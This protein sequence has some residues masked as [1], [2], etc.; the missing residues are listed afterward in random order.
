MRQN[1]Y[2]CCRCGREQRTQIEVDS[3]PIGWALITFERAF[4][5]A[6]EGKQQ[7]KN[8]HVI[9][10]RLRIVLRGRAD[11]S[12]KGLAR[13]R[14]V[15]R[16]WRCLVMPSSYEVKQRQRADTALTILKWPAIGLLIGGGVL[17]VGRIFGPPIADTLGHQAGEGF[18]RGM[19]EA[20][21]KIAQ[22]RQQLNIAGWGRYR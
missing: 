15:V 2:T 16:S 6:A 1:L 14:Q 5:E 21:D 17:L 3:A 19:V 4:V 7:V 10:A 22:V 18:A 12:R 11:L 13:S 20:R 9:D 8:E